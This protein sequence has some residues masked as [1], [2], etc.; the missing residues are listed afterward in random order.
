MAA[1]RHR[2]AG[3]T[4]R[5]RQVRLLAWVGLAG[6]AAFALGA[7]L[8][9]VLT[10]RP[11]WYM[12]EFA[13]GPYG[14]LWSAAV[15]SFVVGGAALTLGVRRLLPAT[16]ARRRGVALL[17]LAGC[18]SLLLASFPVDASLDRQTPAGVIHNVSAIWTFIALVLSMVALAPAFH[19]A[20]PWRPMGIASGLLGLL[21]GASFVV[22]FLGNIEAKPF[23]ML[24]QRVMV[25]L[26]AS[27]FVLLAVGLVRVAPPSPAR[28]TP[29]TAAK[30]ATPLGRAV[31][32][33]TLRRLVAGAP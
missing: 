16:P 8:L 32:L 1:G 29:R 7:V 33:G 10:R 2:G 31:R 24:A 3:W 4:R 23:V 26:I 15:Y 12:S 5:R 19:A 13:N 21:V 17:C 30:R 9:H 14:W 20:G 28:R 22:Y 27:W 18:G 11:P 25:C 6:I